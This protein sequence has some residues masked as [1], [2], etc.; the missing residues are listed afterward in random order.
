MIQDLR[1]ADVSVQRAC[2]LLGLSRATCYY[3]PVDKT[4]ALLEATELRDRIE[5]IIVDT[6]GYG[7]RRVAAQLRRDGHCVNHKRVLSV[8]RNESLLC[9][10]KRRWV[11]TTDSEHGLTVFPNLIKGLTVTDVNQVWVSDIT[12]IRLPR[13]FCYLAAVLDACS[14]RVVGWRLSLSLD[15]GFALSALEMALRD[16]G[17][18]EGFIH[19]S[20]RGVQYACRQYVERLRV[21]G[22][23]ISM[24]SRGCPRENAQAESF[25][26]TLKIEEVHLQEYESFIEAEA[27]IRNFIEDVYNRKRLHSAL[28]YVPPVE[29]EELLQT[30]H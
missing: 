21:A 7:Y 23:R 1:P 18:K 14:R 15:A 27:S 11:P 2:E 20:D 25:F 3:S 17:P 30:P 29:F 16:R 12:Y 6:R 4:A 22:A 5:K 28:G 9:Q 26:R 24:S 13:N 10:I 19:H 8:M